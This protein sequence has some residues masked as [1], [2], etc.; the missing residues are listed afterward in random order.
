[1]APPKV[2]DKGGEK[3]VDGRVRKQGPREIG[4][5]TG[6][7]PAKFDTEPKKKNGAKKTEEEEAPAEHRNQ[8]S[9]EFENLMKAHDTEMLADANADEVPEFE[10]EPEEELGDS[11]Q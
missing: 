9:L 3:I 1:M 10:S 8:N 5:N 2:N 7:K 11:V 4:R 6:W